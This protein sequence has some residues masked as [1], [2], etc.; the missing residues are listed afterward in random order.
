MIEL[1]P[2]QNPCLNS[3]YH[4]HFSSTNGGKSGEPDSTVTTIYMTLKSVYKTDHY[5]YR[6]N[7]CI[8]CT[9][10]TSITSLSN[11]GSYCTH[12]LSM[13]FPS[14]EKWAKLHCEGQL[15]WL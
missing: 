3:E 4:V 14:S 7:S 1:M 12:E 15:D 9:L 6:K 2:L 5:T 13:S 10:L 8:I 11:S